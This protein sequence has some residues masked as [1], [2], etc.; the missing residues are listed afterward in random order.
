MSPRHE[1]YYHPTQH[2]RLKING[3]KEKRALLNF[4]AG[5]LDSDWPLAPSDVRRCPSIPGPLV[6]SECGGMEYIMPMLSREHLLRLSWQVA[7][8]LELPGFIKARVRRWAVEEECLKKGAKCA[9]HAQGQE[10]KA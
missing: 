5:K 1:T 8:T 3:N 7:G 2:I 10:V 9:V 4:I 6:C